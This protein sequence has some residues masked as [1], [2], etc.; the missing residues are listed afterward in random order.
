MVLTSKEDFNYYTE[1]ALNNDIHHQA[2]VAKIYDERAWDYMLQG[3]LFYAE[4]RQV[5]EIQGNPFRRRDSRRKL[6][7][8]TRE[9]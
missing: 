2:M 7:Q 5:A 4:R 6:T 3:I 9:R 1:A 8:T